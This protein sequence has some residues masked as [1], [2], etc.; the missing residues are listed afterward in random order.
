VLA[1]IL[2]MGV[3]LLNYLLCHRVDPVSAFPYQ[4]NRTVTCANRE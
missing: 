4:L 3:L 2:G 1:V